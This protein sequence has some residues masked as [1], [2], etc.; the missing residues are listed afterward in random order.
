MKA[1]TMT[2]KTFVRSMLLF[3]AAC[4]GATATRANVSR[5]VNLADMRL[6][7]IVVSEDAIPS[8]QYAAQELRE[9]FAL[10]TGVDLRILPGPEQSALHIFVGPD[11]TA[12]IPGFADRDFGLE[13]FRI[14]IRDG[15][16]AIAGGRARG[17][18]YGVYT[19][20]EDYLGVRFLTRDHTHAPPVG[21][22]RVVGP[23]DRT[24]HPALAYRFANYGESVANPLFAA[25]LRC[26]GVSRHFVARNT[27]FGA[28]T[29]D[30]RIGGDPGTVLINHSFHG[31]LPAARYGAN[32]P[33]YY[34]L[35][36]GKR[37][38]DGQPCLTNPDVKSI[39]TKAV[40]DHLAVRPRQAVVN[41]CQN[42]GNGNQC[43]CEPCTALNEREQT[44]MGSLLPLVN[45]VADVVAKKHPGIDVGTLAY[46]HTQK[47]PRTIRPRPNV[48]IQLCSVRARF[49]E[50]ISDPT[51]TQNAG[52]RKALEGW[53]NIC[54]NIGIWNYNLNH[55]HY[56][57]PNPN[58]RVV[59]PNIRFFVAN[60]VRSVFMQSP[61][62]LATEFSDLKNYVTS[63]LLWDPN[64]SGRRLRDEFLRLHYR[65]AAPPIRR[66]LELLHDNADV[67]T[68][69]RG[70]V[71][72][73]GPARNFGID[74]PMV[75]AGLDLFAEA[76]TLADD[77]V[78][79]ARVEK[80]SIA[81]YCAAVSDVVTW[82]GREQKM[83]FRNDKRPDGP[84]PPLVVNAR[85]HFRMLV[86]LSRTHGVTL[87]GE[88]GPF[89]KMVAMFRRIYG[90]AEG[91][92]F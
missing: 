83:D 71:H 18:L 7:S 66:Y 30:P 33:E 2:H 28:E 72:F 17:T 63:R 46:N 13:D 82:A 52:F 78:V 10:C 49:N 85:P 86:E 43:R 84:L 6:W 87:W 69:G 76:V 23:V 74:E 56:L 55:H 68:K 26:N 16:I 92:G 79:R 70:Y 35:I 34:A 22:W 90:L 36:D 59:E 44:P 73:A 81:V 75:L 29:D 51:S 27:N 31:L 32:H 42:D 91:E 8:E 20:L 38:I 40:L 1:S 11:A 64:D 19:F 60:N 89:D 21:G 53:K 37:N 9:H 5:G 4:L 88:G 39:T 80:A 12:H 61:G 54:S 48:R 65:K 3:L 47:P 25:R 58:M 15:V 57:Q 62:G 67:K 24:F 14:L 45:A 50:P 41:V 77:V